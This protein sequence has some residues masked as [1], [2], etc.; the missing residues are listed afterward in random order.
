MGSAAG[1]CCRNRLGPPLRRNV[2]SHDPCRETAPDA[3][4]SL[5]DRGA[6]RVPALG[7]GN[8]SCDSKPRRTRRGASARALRRAAYPLPRYSHGTANQRRSRGAARDL[9]GIQRRRGLLDT[10]HGDDLRLHRTS[11]NPDELGA[12][13]ER[14]R[15]PPY[16]LV[17]SR[18]PRRRVSL[19]SV[20]EQC[21]RFH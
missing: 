4:T 8:R 12:P 19:S 14:L 6:R 5:S 13:L 2:A 21:D 10:A 20:K 7:I 1:F 15:S 17:R 18:I 3:R 11:M 9:H 16:A